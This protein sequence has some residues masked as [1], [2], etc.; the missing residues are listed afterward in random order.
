VLT[1]LH[2]RNLAVLDEIELE[3]A[4]GFSALTGE[5]GA[6]KSMLVDALALALGERADSTAVR[7]GA[8]RAEVT[9]IFDV[10]PGSP[11]DAWL[12]SRDLETGADCQIRRVVTPEG[13]SR[14]YINGQPLPMEMLREL[15]AQL[16]EICGQHAHQSLLQ[17]AT[18][19][20]LLDAHGGHDML[21]ATVSGFHKTWA[22]LEKEREQLT[23]QRRDREDRRDLLS[24]QLR[25]LRALNLQDGEVEGMERERILAANAGRIGAGLAQALDHLYDAETGSAHDTIGAVLRQLQ[26]LSALDPALVSAVESL[27]QARIQVAEAVDQLRRRIDGLEHDPAR[28]EQLESRLHSALQL[29]RKHRIEPERLWSLAGIVDA[30]LASLASSDNRLEEIGVGSLRAREALRDESTKLTAARRKAAQALGKA[31]TSNLRG[32]GMADATFTVNVAPQSGEAPGPLGADQVEFLVSTNP[33]QPPGPISRVASGGELSRLSLAIQVVAM[34][35]HGAPTLIFDE[36]DAGIG[37]R[38]A[39]TVG[40]CLKQLSDHRQVLCVTH[41]PQVASQADHHIAVTKATT[42]KTTRTEVVELSASARVN[43]IA[44]MLGG[45][46]ITERTRAHAREMLQNARPR[47]TG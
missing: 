27:E 45:V 5:T 30:E 9:A 35:H 36:V 22:A 42:G 7:T 4:S 37:G 31:V 29:A 38:V 19:R 34:I 17:R 24:Y 18:Q 28:Q 14:G 3:L 1:R 44:R 20:E 13:R 21:L 39:E 12:R 10:A 2:I 8:S 43:E 40:R 25:E 16:V 32:L 11:A 47:R 6:G 46:K 41:L 23:A 33:G 26:S 15:G